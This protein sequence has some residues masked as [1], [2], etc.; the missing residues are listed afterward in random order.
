[1][2]RP[3][4]LLRLSTDAR[5]V[6]R[7]LGVLRPLA[8]L[9][10]A[11]RRAVGLGAYEQAFDAALAAA[12]RPGDVVW[13]VGANVGLYTARFLEWAG[14]EGIVCA[15]E[16]VPACFAGV[17][18]EVGESARAR[19]FN[20]ALGDS[21]GT[22]PMSV[23]SDELG[24][25]HSLAVQPD[26]GARTLEVP[27]RRGDALVAAGEAPSPNVLKIDVEGFEEEVV[28]GLGS[29]LE[30]PTCRAVLIEVHFGLLEARGQRQAPARLC[31][32]LESAGFQLSWPDAS[33]LA[34]LRA[35]R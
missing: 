19:L 25:T 27:V 1:M 15:F 18:A 26:G 7:R 13:D 24:A 5:A 20:V 16:P 8:Q 4:L 21:E 11:L 14:P 3:H 10:I 33:H 31:A 29:L 34:A 28:T 12:I 17:Q 22:L 2:A 35:S 9:R 23:A 30:Q 6:A 32:R